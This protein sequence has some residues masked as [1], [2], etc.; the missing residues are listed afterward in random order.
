MTRFA[1]SLPVAPRAEMISNL[2]WRSL[3]DSDIRAVTLLASECLQTDGGLPLIATEEFL[4]ERYWNLDTG[5][6]WGAFDETGRLLAFAAL[7]RETT[8]QEIRVTVLGQVHPN[9][10]RRGLGTSVMQWSEAQAREILSDSQTDLP[11]IFRVATESLTDEAARFYAKHYLIQTFGEKVMRYDLKKPL[12][13]TRL[14]EGLQMETWTEARAKLFFQAYQDSFCE[15]P[16][17]PG[18]SFETWRDWIAGDET[19][20]PEKS[21][22]VCHNALPVAFLACAENYIEQ[23]GVH[24]AW[25]RQGIASALLAETLSRLCA[26]DHADALLTV[27]DNNPTATEVYLKFGFDLIGRRARFEK[28][29]S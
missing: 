12:P 18:W 24:P 4:R 21:F 29:L 22:L 15:R 23:I 10:R 28:R 5:A 2:T 7:R 1:S 19:F 3:T 26:E 16:G 8:P 13:E 6:A 14:S 25:R 17:F 27:A 9:Y 20:C 11:Q